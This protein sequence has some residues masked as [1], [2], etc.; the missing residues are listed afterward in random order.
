MPGARWAAWIAAVGFSTL[1]AFLPGCGGGGGGGGST[2][3]IVR[4]EIPE[5][6]EFPLE[7][8]FLNDDI[9]ITFN[10]RLDPAS[11]SSQT[12]RILQGPDFVEEAE[13]EFE[14]LDN[15]IQFRPTRRFRSRR[16][17]R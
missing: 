2:L 8:V 3:E 6:G 10:L 14:V 11:V 17:G 15:V 13:G 12:V 16:C 7:G 9:L 4:A 5:L 1:I